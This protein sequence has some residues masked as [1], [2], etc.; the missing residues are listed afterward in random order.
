MTN[1]KNQLK[2]GDLVLLNSGD[3]YMYLPDYFG[4]PALVRNTGYVYLKSYDDNLTF[5]E[6]TSYDVDSIYRTSS[7]GLGFSLIQTIR[8]DY[9]LI[10]KRKNVIKLTLKEIAEKYGVDKVIITE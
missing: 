8:E 4:F 2:S 6:D 1:I 10:W 7:R 3:I 5:T 9:E